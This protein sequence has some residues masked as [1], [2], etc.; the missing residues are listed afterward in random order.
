MNRPS[1]KDIKAALDQL[2]NPNK[3]EAGSTQPT[4]NLTEKKQS[5]RIRKQGV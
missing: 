2:K 4:P 3:G 1:K 5:K